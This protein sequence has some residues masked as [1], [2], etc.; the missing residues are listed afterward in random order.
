MG[1]PDLHYAV[2]G[3]V[4]IIEMARPPV[5][6]IDLAFIDAIIEAFRTAGADDDVRAVVLTS[7]VPGMFCAGLDLSVIKGMTG[8]SFRQ[9]LE[10]L[11]L[12]LYDVQFTLGKPSIAA[13][14][15]TARGGGMTLAVSCNIILAEKDATL[16]YPE[17]KVGIMPGIHFLHLPR[18]I[19]RHRAFELLFSGEPFAPDEAERLGLI[20][21]AVHAGQSRAIALSMARHMA[22]ISP[23]VM[24]RARDTFMQANDQGYRRDLEAV[25][26]AM[27]A[28][29]ET[30][31]AQEGVAAFVEKR[32][33]RW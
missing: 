16:G 6:A 23:V 12:E 15:G 32:P 28:L 19:G 22:A 21:R 31:E 17:L 18:Q 3:Q 30:D 5:N 20:N 14:N 9:V 2:D 10:K 7:G 1:H 29:V 13:V 25:V 24:H 8:A 33:P 4:A 11:Y 26:N 27:C